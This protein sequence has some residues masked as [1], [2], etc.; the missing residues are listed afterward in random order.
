[1]PGSA[2]GIRSGKT[3]VELGVKDRLDRPVTVVEHVDVAIDL[4]RGLDGR[5][6]PGLD[7]SSHVFC[8][9]PHGIKDEGQGDEDGGGEEESVHVIQAKGRAWGGATLRFARLPSEGASCFLLPSPFWNLKH[10]VI[11]LTLRGKSS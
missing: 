3:Y 2:S 9:N 10:E 7:E 4:S 1:M 5:R 6:V 11:V 8:P